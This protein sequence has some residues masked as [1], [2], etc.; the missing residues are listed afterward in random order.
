M[1]WQEDIDNVP[2]EYSHK[3]EIKGTNYLLNYTAGAPHLYYRLA[4]KISSFEPVS[5]NQNIAIIDNTKVKIH[6]DEV[7]DPCKFEVL[8][9][10][11][12][13]YAHDSRQPVQLGLEF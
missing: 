13:S 3:L 9:S 8:D 6:L 4:D 12:E 7:G 1:S 2:Y 10:T 11:S 5:V